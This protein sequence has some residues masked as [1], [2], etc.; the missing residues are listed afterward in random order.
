MELCNRVSK[1]VKKAPNELK[2][3]F[4]AFLDEILDILSEGRKIE[5]RGFGSFKSKKREKRVGRN[6]RTG[7]I[8]NI[9]GYTAPTFKFSK[10]A[11]KIFDFKLTKT[12][13]GQKASIKKKRS[14]SK[15]ENDP[16]PQ[17][18][19]DEQ[20]VDTFSPT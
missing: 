15:K 4:E 1:R 18:E 17:Q 11:Q 20:L 5:I 2:P 12:E 9:P 6:P 7:D 14:R 8:I 16:N 19:S 3:L 13:E 10:D